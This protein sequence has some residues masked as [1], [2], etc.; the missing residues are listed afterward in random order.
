M[1]TVHDISQTLSIPD[2]RV[3][4]L[5]DTFAP[6]VPYGGGGNKPRRYPAWVTA[7]IADIEEQLSEGKSGADVSSSIKDKYGRQNLAQ[8]PK[9]K[10]IER[11]LW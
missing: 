1:V 9:P 8:A 10:H 6:W 11:M 2:D 3:H 5:L 7:A 4:D